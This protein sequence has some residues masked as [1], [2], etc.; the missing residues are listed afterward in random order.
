MAQVNSA[1]SLD[2]MRIVWWISHS[3]I[4][5]SSALD[6]WQH[7]SHTRGKSC[8]PARHLSGRTQSQISKRC[9]PIALRVSSITTGH[10]V[11]RKDVDLK[12]MGSENNEGNTTGSHLMTPLPLLQQILQYQVVFELF[13]NRLFWVFIKSWKTSAVSTTVWMVESQLYKL[14]GT[15]DTFA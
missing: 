7:I 13:M 5:P 4:T 3:L 2:R 14:R 1:T 12:R 11:L 8:R 10:Y 6:I 9:L 15:S